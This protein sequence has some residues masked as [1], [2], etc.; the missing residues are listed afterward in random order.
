MNRRAF[1]LGWSGILVGSGSG[2]VLARGGSSSRSSGSRTTSTSSHGSSSSTTVRGHT[3]KDG[4]YVPAH[5][6]SN[7]DGSKTNNWSSKGNVNP[8][9]G[10]Q[11]TQ[12]PN[13][14]PRPGNQ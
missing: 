7:P 8:Y 6:R 14:P 13:R 12:D 10:K 9:T 3:R 4:T 11:G 1:L 2:Y 5:K